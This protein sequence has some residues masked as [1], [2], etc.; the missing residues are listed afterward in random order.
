MLARLVFD[1]SRRS[2]QDFLDLVRPDADDRRATLRRLSDY[3]RKCAGGF[4]PGTLE[5]NVGLTKSVG[6][7]TFTDNPTAADTF[8]IGNVVFTA[9]NSG[10]IAN[11]WNITSGG[12]AGA[13]AAGNAASV[14]ALV[15]EHASLSK[16]ITAVAVLGVVRFTVE[17][18]GDIG[19]GLQMSESLGNATI[20]GF[21]TQDTG[22]DGDLFSLSF[23]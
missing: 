21:V 7:L 20:S 19:N 1:S 6:T 14:A 10:A 15:N 3:F 11:E 12:T 16:F 13:D 18:P 22:D 8:T 23:L 2:A 5:M 4:E 17:V 9:R